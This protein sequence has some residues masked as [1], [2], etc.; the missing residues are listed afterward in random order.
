MNEN[1]NE[2][3]IEDSNIDIEPNLTVAPPHYKG[4]KSS[5]HALSRTSLID[6]NKNIEKKITL[7]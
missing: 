4:N 6:L 7:T 5:M 3:N 2:S 1:H